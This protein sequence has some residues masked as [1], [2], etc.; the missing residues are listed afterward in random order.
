MKNDIRPTKVYDEL[1]AAACLEK[2]TP[3]YLGEMAAH[4]NTK[5]AAGKRCRIRKGHEKQTC[6]WQR[7]R[8]NDN[9]AA[10]K[11]REEKKVA[12]AAGSGSAERAR[13]VGGSEAA[14]G[15][16]QVAAECAVDGWFCCERENQD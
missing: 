3:G 6:D 11:K 5:L 4:P 13:R 12:T 7:N 14:Q 10:Q 16:R 8:L 2:D 9:V 1:A 15:R